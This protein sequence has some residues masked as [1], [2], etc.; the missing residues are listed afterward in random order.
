MTNEE[1]ILS[2]GKTKGKH[3]LGFYDMGYRLEVIKEWL[4]R[5]K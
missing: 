1:K 2:R 5:Q 4:S 3:T